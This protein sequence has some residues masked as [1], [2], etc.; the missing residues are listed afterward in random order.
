MSTDT[1]FITNQRGQSL[2]DRFVTLIGND[3][4]A[5]DCLVGYFYS[6]G[7]HLLSPTLQQT[8]KI[9]ILI[10][11]STDTQTFDLIQKSKKQTEF[12]LSHAETKDVYVQAVVSELDQVEE[13]KNTEAGIDLFVKWLAAK[14]LE[15]RAFPSANLHAKL[16]IITHHKG[17]RDKGRVVTGSSN[18]SISGLKGNLELNVELKDAPDYHFALDKFNELWEQSVD[19]SEKYIQTVQKKT[20]FNDE[21]SPYEL[22][23]KCLYEYFQEEINQTADEDAYIPADYMRLAYQDQAVTSA[24]QII[25]KFGGVFL[26]DVVGLGKTYISALLAQRLRNDGR[27][28]V[29]AP[30]HVLDRNNQGSW[31]NVFYAFDVNARF[32]SVGQL[33]KIIQEGTDRFK[34]VFIDEAHRFRS[35]D[36][37]TYAKLSQICFGKQVVLVTATPYNNKPSDILSLIKLFQKPHDSTIPNHRNLQSFFTNLENRAKKYDRRSDYENYIRVI[38]E[39]ARA[40]RENI[41]KHLMVRRTRGEVVKHFKQ[42]IEQQGLKFPEV[43]KPTPLFYK[44]NVAEELVFSETIKLMKSLTYARYVPMLYLVEGLRPQEVTGQRN[45]MGFVKTLIVKRMESSIIA[46]ESTLNRLLRSYEVFLK[47]YELG[48]VYFSPKHASKIFDAIELDNDEAIDKLIESGRAERF[49]S[50]SFDKKLHDDLQADIVIIKRILALWETIDRDP[51]L[52]ELLSHLRSNKVLKE[53]KIIIFTEAEV[54]ANYLREKIEAETGR[55]TLAFSGHSSAVD[56]VKVIDNFDAKARDKKDDYDILVT[57][58]VLAEGVNLHRS[59]VIINYDIPWNPTRLMQ[60]VGRINRVGTAFEKIYTFNFFPTKELNDEIALQEA[61]EAKI[62][63]FIEM[64]GAD[65]K[66]LTESEEVSPKGLFEILNSKDV[67]EDESDAQ[68]SE[69]KYLRVIQTVRDKDPSLFEKIKNLPRK[70]RSCRVDGKRKTDGLITYFRKGYLTKFI[71]SDVAATQEID[72]FQAAKTLECIPEAKR[73]KLSAA[74]NDAFYEF[75]DKNRDGFIAATD[76]VEEEAGTQRGSRNIL[77]RLREFVKIV[78]KDARMTEF[79]QDFLKDVM[80]AL[81]SGV[82]PKKDAQAMV[83][84]MEDTGSDI[85]KMLNIMRSGINPTFLRPTE[86]NKRKELREKREVV[87]SLYTKA[88]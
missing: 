31:P 83:K 70:A 6:S 81:E 16:Y 41:L 46:F 32:E 42:D 44:L 3:T 49:P 48:D 38:R 86:T 57:T 29:L 45:M 68:N 26:S 24:R 63:S 2:A 1:R 73:A 43:Q 37:E 58:E 52:L 10:G 40:V 61:A 11:L 69:L 77:T 13:N 54:T 23:L 36:T 53:N 65:A 4:E 80:A 30:P 59:N 55:K 12:N 66:L 8:D 50:D 19:V 7:F 22:Y 71:L 72:F 47:A 51:K 25:K 56:R 78:R 62:E 33:D 14:K 34:T 85:I 21:I 82:I 76:P 75:Y 74:D 27:I 87:L 84:K 79:D 28:L 20:W 15:V 18:F 17:S 9:R 67:L 64:L 88:G 39:N 5:F 35:D 60:R